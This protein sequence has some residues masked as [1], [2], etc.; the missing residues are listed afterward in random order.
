MKT[1]ELKRLLK[2]NGCYRLRKGGNHDIW[3]NPQT[4]ATA[5]IPRHDAQEVRPGTLRSIM[6]ALL[7]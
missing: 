4:G 6:A 1:N 7:G 3:V 5:P 2:H